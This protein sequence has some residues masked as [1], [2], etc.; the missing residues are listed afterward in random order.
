MIHLY[1][2][3]EYTVKFFNEKKKLPNNLMI[4]SD[5]FDENK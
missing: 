3:N 4:L 5:L 1:V 2:N